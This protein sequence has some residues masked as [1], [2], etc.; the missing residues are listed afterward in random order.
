[1]LDACR[2]NPLADQLL[3]QANPA[4]AVTI[5]R[6]LARIKQ[7][8]GTVIAYSTQP[9][10]VA[11]DGEGRNSPFAAAFIQQVGKPGVEIGPLSAASPPMSTRRPTS[12]NC[13]K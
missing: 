8:A 11:A 9:G 13:L 4:R 3:A 10:A 6:G 2:D 1:M 12:G 7:T 5:I